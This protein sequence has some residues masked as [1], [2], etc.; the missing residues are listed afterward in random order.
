MMLTM[1]LT[2][3]MIGKFFFILLYCNNDGADVD[4]GDN[5]ESQ[6]HSTSLGFELICTNATQHLIL[7]MILYSETTQ[8]IVSLVKFLT[9]CDLL[10]LKLTSALHLNLQM[11]FHV[12]LKKNAQVCKNVKSYIISKF[13]NDHLNSDLYFLHF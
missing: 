9:F 12:R 7:L 2:L 3:V 8:N 5:L 1:M 10:R 13:S 4:N 6:P 11:R